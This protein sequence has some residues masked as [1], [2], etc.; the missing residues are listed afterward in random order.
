M[1]TWDPLSIFKYLTGSPAMHI[2]MLINYTLTS[3]YDLDDIKLIS[4]EEEKLEYFEQK[5]KLI[6]MMYLAHGIAAASHLI[7]ETG[8]AEL[9]ICKRPSMVVPVYSLFLQIICY[10]GLIIFEADYFYY[11]L[12]ATIN[13]PGNGYDE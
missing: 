4:D 13:T 11:S 3:R 8:V 5:T 1:R 6:S 9:L 7:F 2:V 12:I 10:Q